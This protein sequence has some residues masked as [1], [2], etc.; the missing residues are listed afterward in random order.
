MVPCW[1]A[2]GEA[3]ICRA[4]CRCEQRS[5]DAY[6]HSLHTLFFW[7]HIWMV[8]LRSVQKCV[9]GTPSSLRSISHKPYTCI[10]RINLHCQVF[11]LCLCLCDDEVGLLFL[12]EE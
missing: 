10:S 7:L 12:V 9:Y 3:Y 11:L 6:F 1:V 5:D 4:Y 8:F 2:W